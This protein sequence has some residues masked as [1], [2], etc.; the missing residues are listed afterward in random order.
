[1]KYAIAFNNKT[2]DV[3][4]ADFSDLEIDFKFA[5]IAAQ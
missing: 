3:S 2:I 5:P 4:S 1:M